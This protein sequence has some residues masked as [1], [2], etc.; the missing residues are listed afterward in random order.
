MV[1]A[2]WLQLPSQLRYSML[3]PLIA[4][5]FTLRQT[6][7]ISLCVCSSLPR[8][9][10]ISLVAVFL[11]WGWNCRPCSQLSSHRSAQRCSE[12]S[13]WTLLTCWLQ[14][15]ASSRCSMKRP[16]SEYPAATENFAWAAIPKKYL[17]VSGM[18]YKNTTGLPSWPRNV[19]RKKTRAIRINIFIQ[20]S[21]K[22]NT[23]IQNNTD[24]L[25]K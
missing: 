14:P 21:G 12:A 2:F 4:Q 5:P 11:A 22:N 3:E 18:Q 23:I 24:L 8:R 9:S 10:F 19:S 15:T 16:P 6:L 1:I 20:K 7:R 13:C 25:L 17:K